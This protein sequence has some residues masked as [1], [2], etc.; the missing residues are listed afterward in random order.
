MYLNMINSPMVI[1][2]SLQLP[3]SVCAET[4]KALSALAIIYAFALTAVQ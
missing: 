3:L 4:V 1:R 2:T